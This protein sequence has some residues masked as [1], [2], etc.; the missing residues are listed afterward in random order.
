MRHQGLNYAAVGA[1]VIAM[2]LAVIGATVALSGGTGPRDHYS[3]VFDNVADVKFGTQVRYEGFPVGQVESIEPIVEEGATVFLLEVSVEEGFV[4]PAD[5]VARIHSSQFLGAKTVE[6]QRGSAA[7]AL[8]PGERMASAPAA[9]MF[10]AMAS[11]AGQVNELSSEGLKPLLA[12][13]T[14]LVD[15]AN[16]LLDDDVAPMIGSLNAVA[17]D[18][19]GRVPEITGELLGFMQELNVTL[20]SVQQLLSEQNVAGV[21]QTVENVN[22]VSRDLV[23]ISQ[24]VQGTLVQLDSIVTTLEGVVDKN[25]GNVNA[26]LDDT[27]YILRSIAQNIDSINHNLAGTSRNMNEFSRLIR[28]NPSLLLGGSAPE[29]VSVETPSASSRATSSRRDN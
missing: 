25:Q 20:A 2:L 19:R 15:N 9:D 7:T 11:V 14:A 29:E 18:T 10:A 5:S 27:R 12:R 23:T 28:Q 26:A 21:Q 17:Q 24:T 6:I 16:H 8:Q 3:L 22:T 4:I 1:F 13:L